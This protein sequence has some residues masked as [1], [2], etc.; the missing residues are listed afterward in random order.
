MEEGENAWNVENLI[1]WIQFTAEIIKLRR[2]S[3]IS[4][5]KFYLQHQIPVFEKPRALH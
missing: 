3:N 2:I 5:I 1:H 4:Q